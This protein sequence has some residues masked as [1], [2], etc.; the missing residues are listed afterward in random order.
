MSPSPPTSPPPFPP[1]QFHRWIGMVVLL[2]GVVIGLL[3]WLHFEQTHT[4]NEA[5]RRVGELRQARLDLVRGFVQATLDSGGDAP[6]SREAGIALLLQAVTSFERALRVQGA[7]NPADVEAFRASVEDFRAQLEI[8]RRRPTT[9]GRDVVSL[10]VAFADLE[11]RAARVDVRGQHEIEVLGT[12]ADR[13]FAWSLAGSLL[14]LGLIVAIVQSLARRDA[15]ALAE[16]TRLDESRRA[17]ERRY[18]RLF[19]QAP[20]A[21]AYVTAAGVIRDRNARFTATFGYGEDE[22]RTLAEWWPRAYPDPELRRQVIETW[23]AALDRAART[24]EDIEPREYR[25]TCQDGTV[26]TMLGSGITLD[27]G[28]LAVFLDI[29]ERV[30]AEIAL[31]E[32]EARFRSISSAAQDAVIILNERDEIEFWNAAAERIFGHTAAEVV[33]RNLHET[34]SPPR[35]RDSFRIGFAAFRRTGDGAMVG[36]T[37]ELVAL[38]KDGTE[39]PVEL[40]LSAVRQNGQ[41]MGIGILRD[42][43]ERKRV[44]EELDRHRHHLEEVV[45]ERTRELAQAKE[46]AERATAAKSIF[47]AN[48]SHEI[49]TPLNAILGFAQIG[50]RDSARRAEHERF[51][52]IVEA[53]Q[54]LQQV[55][56][57][58]LDASKIE[59]GKMTIEAIAMDPGEVVDLAVDMLALRAQTRGV[60]FVVEEAPDLPGR[61][62]GD[63]LRLR[64]VLVNLL[65]NAVK[66]T[67]AGGTVTLSVETDGETLRFRVAD[68]GIGITPDAA[69]VLF[70]PFEQSDS[71]TTRLFGGTGLGLSISR[72]LVTLMGGTIALASVPGEG[73]TFTVSLPLRE[74]ERAPPWPPTEIAL[75]AVPEDEAAQLSIAAPATR[76]LATAEAPAPGS[77]LVVEAAALVDPSVLALART[78]LARR[79]RMAILTGAGFG[80]SLPPGMEAA[81]L[82]QRPLRPRHL[83]RLTSGPVPLPPAGMVGTRLAGLRILCAEDNPINRLVLEDMLVGEGASV[84]CFENGKLAL[85]H[86]REVGA[87]AVDL[88]LTDVQMPDLD[89]YDLAL[90]VAELAPGLP[91]IGLTAHTSD[92]D[93]QRCLSARMVEHVMKPVALDTLLAAIRRHVP[94]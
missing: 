24:G 59:S 46:E 52:R 77:L 5:A 61:C 3:S 17:S 91:V 4:L 40:S 20:V 70:N 65:G 22:V 57:D 6:Y 43:S 62:R 37:L 53:G 47:L 71:S 9:G 75:L 50:E 11:R 73:S 7:A 8:W 10:R 66:F 49:R 81:S 1:P 25:T 54:G 42:I 94:G 41:W 30:A 78:H 13:V 29:S 56:D 80:E 32:S 18:L 44:L 68:T 36:R 74:A 15:R 85:N 76:R 60:H 79:G 33:G 87:A 64:Q 55:I 83:K 45:Q 14:A 2:G 72:D 27:D 38:R 88:V 35:F 86:L 82:V 48:M 63:P 26:R 12:T 93:R 90:A 19:D 16:R 39:F 34:L 21:L 92:E 58:I 67:P 23:T 84:T 28:Y 89:G 51:A 31:R 69:R